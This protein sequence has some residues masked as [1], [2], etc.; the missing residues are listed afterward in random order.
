[1]TVQFDQE[2]R[3]IH[4]VGQVHLPL[5]NTKD[6]YNLVAGEYICNII[7]SNG[8]QI[9][10]PFN[11]TEPANSFGP[12]TYSSKDVSCKDGMI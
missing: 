9:V 12:V 5:S 3:H 8:C 4:I 1:M 6:I 2:H 7:D 10:A 11:V